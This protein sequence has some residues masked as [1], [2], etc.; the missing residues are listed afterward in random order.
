MQVSTQIRS[1]SLPGVWE[2]AERDFFVKHYSGGSAFIEAQFYG[3]TVRLRAKVSGVLGGVMHAT[4]TLATFSVRTDDDESIAQAIDSLE[5]LLKDKIEQG[6]P[7]TVR[8]FTVIGV[9]QATSDVTADQV[10]AH[11]P[12]SA[13]VSAAEIRKDQSVDL[14][15]AVPGW[16]N[17]GVDVAFVDGQAF[18]GIE[19]LRAEHGD[20]IYE[21]TSEKIFAVLNDYA[22]RVADT[23]GQSFAQMSVDLLDDLDRCEIVSAAMQAPHPELIEQHGFNAIKDAL[24]KKGVLEF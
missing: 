14:L 4:E 21:L 18:G 15:A 6:G 3:D 2:E 22:L 13:L 11:S 5:R 7:A 19:A 17:E 16:Y 12:G 20:P 23:Q 10:W 1:T 9:D 8:K 24:V